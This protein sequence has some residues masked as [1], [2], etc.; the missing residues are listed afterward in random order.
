M[1]KQ[2]KNKSNLKYMTPAE[3]EELNKQPTS[4]LLKGYLT[5]QKALR[6]I[7]KRKSQDTDLK[8]LK[9]QIKKHREESPDNKT[10]EEMKKLKDRLREIKQEIDAEIPE[11]LQEL[12]DKN[13]DYREDQGYPKEKAKIIQRIIDSRGEK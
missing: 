10:L 6:D 2:Q 1:A 3:V 9:E 11:L 13:A 8:L 7:A 12:K 5:Q 4:E